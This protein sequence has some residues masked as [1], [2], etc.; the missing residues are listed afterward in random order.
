MAAPDL[1]GYGGAARTN[2]HI[3]GP[4]IVTFA[5]IAIS[6]SVRS[7]RRVTSILGIWLILSPIVFDYSMLQTMHSLLIGI[8]VVLMARM[9][10]SLKERFGGG[11]TDLW[12]GRAALHQ[13]R[14]RDILNS[15]LDEP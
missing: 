5:M 8:L 1:L 15:E 11:W 4:L 2:D 14:R 12:R 6:E 3:V 13:D 10:G 9:R 7:V